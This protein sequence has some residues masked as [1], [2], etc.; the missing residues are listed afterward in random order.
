M[1]PLTP[2]YFP[3]HVWIQ[4][5]DDFGVEVGEAKRTLNLEL[6]H[7]QIG[8]HIVNPRYQSHELDAHLKGEWTVQEREFKEHAGAPDPTPRNF[9]LYVRE[10]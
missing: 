2:E 6:L 4:P 8:D 3:L 10:R 1:I 7:A 5:V 9:T